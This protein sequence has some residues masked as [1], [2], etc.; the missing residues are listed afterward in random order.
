MKKKVVIVGG[1]YAG[2]SLAKELDSHAEVTLIDLKPAF[3]HSIAAL[4]ATVSPSIL[5]DLI[6]P[7]DKLLKNG[8]FIQ[9]KVRAVFED[10]VL[11]ANDEV[12]EGDIIVVATGSSNGAAFKAGAGSLEA[13]KQASAELHD[14]IQKAAKIAIVGAGAVGVELAGEIAFAHPD[15]DIALIS[16]D[17][18]L[19]PTFPSKVGKQVLE[20]LK[21]SGVEV[22]LGKRAQ[23]LSQTHQA[24]AGPLTLQDGQN[25]DVDLVIPAIGSHPVTDLLTALPGASLAENGR[26]KTDGWFRP[27]H[28]ATVFALGDAADNGDP[29]TAIAVINQAPYLA[30]LIKGFLN[31][32]S[33]EEAKPYKA[34]KKSPI[35]LPIGPKAGVAYLVIATVGNFLTRL[36]KGKDLLIP[37]YRKLLNQ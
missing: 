19:F 28:Y 33:I 7:Y 6:I 8:R 26:V 22:Y 4:R 27:S 12:I 10:H 18:T 14:Q 13:F 17:P 35:I 24:F 36:F 11:L 15:K 34:W 21:A 30:K 3:V 25:L 9:Q 20:K 23:N 37:R 1:G 2:V 31:G 32:T 5:S 16:S 29:M